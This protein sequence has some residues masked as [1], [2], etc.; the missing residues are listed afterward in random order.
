MLDGIIEMEMIR[1]HLGVELNFFIIFWL[2][3]SLFGPYGIKSN[4][5]EMQIG[6]IA[7]ISFDGEKF[8]HTLIITKIEDISDLGKIIISSHTY[9]SF[10]KSIGSY[11]FKKIRFVHIVGGRKF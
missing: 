4:Q 11:K 7:Q 9:D 10:D 2:I 1:A 3:I 6:D 5:N 8:A